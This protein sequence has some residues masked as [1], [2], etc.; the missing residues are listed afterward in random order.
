V[1]EL[2]SAFRKIHVELKPR[3][4]LPILQTEFFPSVGANHSATL[5][6]GT[7][8]IR[9]SDL[10]SDAPVEVLEALAAILLAKLYRKRVDPGHQRAYRRYTLSSEMI[11][12]SR[13]TRAERG[14]RSRTTGP[15]GRL[16]DLNALFEHINALYFEND[17]R[18]PE[19][20]WTQ[21]K[22]R[23]T[24]G[25]YDF[26]QDVIFISRFLDSPDVPHYVVEYVMFHEMLH[27]K[28]GSQIKGLKEIV[29][30]QR[31]ARTN[32]GLNTIERLQRGWTLT[33]RSSQRPQIE[34]WCQRWIHRR[35]GKACGN[36]LQAVAKS[37]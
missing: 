11:E 37:A 7:L 4:P 26:E 5:D 35:C 17:L 21:K 29:H 24:L 9:I 6:K 36:R 32:D 14:R 2:E 19:L 33:S 28:H 8:R 20:S 18:K 27:V 31:F 30:P 13:L 22:A 16:H 23:S 15:N 10:F 12:R 34:T 1:T 25:R 3:T